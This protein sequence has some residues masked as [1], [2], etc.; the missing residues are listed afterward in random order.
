MI[1]VR[2]TPELLQLFR[3]RRIF[4]QVSHGERWNEGAR[5]GLERDCRI[6]PYTSINLGYYL[7]AVMGAFSY[8]HSQLR[9]WLRM[10]RYISMGEGVRFMGDRHPTEWVSTSPLFYGPEP[11]QGMMAYNRDRD[12]PGGVGPRAYP[13]PA[14]R[15]EIG[16]DVWVGDEALIGRGIAIGDGAV[17]AARSVVLHDVPPYAIVV[18]HPAR[19]LRLRFGEAFVERLL[20][21]QWWNYDPAIIEALPIEAP[22]RFL[23][24]LEA[25]LADD[26]PAP[27]EPRPVTYEEIVAAGVVL[28]EN[29]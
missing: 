3:E 10:G 21:A 26:P 5:L 28:T 13:Q 23:D 1:I 15:V 17:V 25:K 24:A 9:P 6:E 12:P 27:F 16:N 2:T 18:G 22:E 4:H 8:S 20:R 29:G 7:P 19:V 14:E 11:L